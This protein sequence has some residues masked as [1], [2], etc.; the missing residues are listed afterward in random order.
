MPYH[1]GE[2]TR[3]HYPNLHNFVV[4]KILDSNCLVNKTR[5][6]NLEIFQ[7]PVFHGGEG[8]TLEMR[9]FSYATS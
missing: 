2:E 3:E 1:H 6:G 9:L 7:D 5:E 4:T 8:A